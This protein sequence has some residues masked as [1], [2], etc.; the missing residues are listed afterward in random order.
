MPCTNQR[1]IRISSD[2]DLAPSLRGGKKIRGLRFLNDVFFGKNFPFHGPNFWWPFFVIDQVF[3]IFP[4]FSHAGF[5]VSSLCYMSYRLWHF[6][7]RKTT[8]SENNSFMTLFLLCSYFR[9]HP[10]TL[11]YICEG[12]MHGP[13]PTSNFWGT[14]PNPPRSPPLHAHIQHKVLTFG[15]PRRGDTHPLRFFRYH[16]FCIWNKILTF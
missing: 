16:I 12:R 10:T 11:A 1:M 2:G 3:Q 8:I 7:T 9:A 13:S 14:A 4:F 15:L 6:L 5:S